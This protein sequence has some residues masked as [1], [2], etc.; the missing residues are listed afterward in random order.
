MSFLI[1]LH[2]SI[3]TLMSNYLNPLIFLNFVFSI[4]SFGRVIF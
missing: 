2:T 3:V 1:V 4:L